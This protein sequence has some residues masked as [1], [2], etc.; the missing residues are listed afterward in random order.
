MRSL[1]ALCSAM[2][3]CFSGLFYFNVPQ[4]LVGIYGPSDDIELLERAY[5]LQRADV[6]VM[7]RRLLQ[8]E[9]HDP[10]DTLEAPAAG[11][12]LYDCDNYNIVALSND[13]FAKKL[14]DTGVIYTVFP[15][16]S[17]TY[18]VVDVEHGVINHLPNRELP[19]A[20]RAQLD[21]YLP[22]LAK[23]RDASMNGVTHSRYLLSAGLLEQLERN[24]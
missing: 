13:R 4:A 12:S 22:T 2:A 16:S 5:A 17:T 21:G 14:T 1:Y 7:Q 11:T 19:D 9:L 8:D 10:T 18:G 3:L 6:E 24:R 23:C 15:G 20:I